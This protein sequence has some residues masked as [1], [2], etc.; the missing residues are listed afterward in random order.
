MRRNDAMGA[1][2][3]RARGDGVLR[4]PTRLTARLCSRWGPWLALTVSNPALEA[5]KVDAGLLVDA[6]VAARAGRAPRRLAAQ[7]R[8]CPAPRLLA[9]VRGRALAAGRPRGARFLPWVPATSLWNRHCHA[10]EQARV[11][12]VEDDQRRK[13]C[14]SLSP[15]TGYGDDAH[16]GRHARARSPRVPALPR[17]RGARRRRVGGAHVVERAAERVAVVYPA[18]AFS[19]FTNSTAC[20]TAR[21]SGDGWVGAA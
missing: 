8:S 3:A 4:M 7:P 18:R 12:G 21:S 9:R 10:I 17:D 1:P 13:I 5:S 2:L 16:G 6:G 14:I 11:D 20:S 15:P 19:E